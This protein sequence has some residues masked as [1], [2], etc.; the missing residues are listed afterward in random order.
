MTSQFT[1]E[2]VEVA[3]GST[4]SASIPDTSEFALEK[5]KA[6]PLS[7]PG[8]HAKPGQLHAHWRE[9]ELCPNA[10]SRDELQRQHRV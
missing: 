1:P 4:T 10:S 9:L 7:L 3:Q 2:D 8:C 5:A 6:T